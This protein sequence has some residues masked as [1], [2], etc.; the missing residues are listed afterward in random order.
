VK[1]PAYNMGMPKESAMALLR[2]Y[3]THAAA[4]AIAEDL[5]KQGKPLD[6]HW[7]RVLEHLRFIQE[8]ETEREQNS[9][10]EGQAIG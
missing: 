5:S 10:P 4:Q 6:T 3:R 2:F 1:D 9:R 8:E 7:R